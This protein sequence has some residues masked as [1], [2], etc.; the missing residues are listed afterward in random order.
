MWTVLE[1]W[2]FFLFSL[3]HQFETLLI[4]M[5]YLVYFWQYP[6]YILIGCMAGRAGS[7]G[8][9]P[10]TPTLSSHTP[11]RDLLMHSFLRAPE[12]YKGRHTLKKGFF[13]SGRTKTP[14]TTKQKT[15]FFKNEKNI[16]KK[17]EPLT[18]RGGGVG[19]PDLSGSTLFF[20]LRLT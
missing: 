9:K 2:Y 8:I 7:V 19:Y 10:P 6:Q 15:L 14:L 12:R 20:Y 17:Y 1:Y 16:L 3:N 13:F 18:S 5:I 4:R 11:G